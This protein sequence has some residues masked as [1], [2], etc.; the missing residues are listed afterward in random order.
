MTESYEVYVGN[1]PA[2]VSKQQLNELFSPLGD[3]VHIWINTKYK[4]VTYA[5]V[6]FA[7]SNTCNK[8][9]KRYHNYELDFFKLIVRRSFKTITFGKQKSILLDLK[10]KTGVSKGHT[11]KKILNKNLR[12]NPDIRESFKMAMQ[13]CDYL[14]DTNQLMQIKHESEQCTLETL[15]ETITRNFKMPRQKKAIAVDIDLTKGK[16]LSVED[17]DRLFNLQFTPTKTTLQTATTTTTTTT[18][19][20]NSEKKIPFELDYR[21]VCE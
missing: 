14:D 12:Q 17:N 1:L 4:T 9:C 5:F 20:T 11:V 18:S 10:K 8:A 19:T 2:N 13:E 7:D 6:G 15:E 3:V 16:L 21:S